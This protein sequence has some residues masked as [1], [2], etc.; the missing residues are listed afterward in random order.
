MKEIAYAWWATL[1][2][3]V[4]VLVIVPAAFMQVQNRK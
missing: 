3:Y 2:P 4:V 1:R